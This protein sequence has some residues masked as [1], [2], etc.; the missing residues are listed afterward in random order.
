MKEFKPRIGQRFIPI[1]KHPPGKGIRCC[2]QLPILYWV[3]T[4]KLT[5]YL[6]ARDSNNDETEWSFKYVDW[7]FEPYKP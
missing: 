7:L 6:E 4:D 1:K 2:P 5:F 3:C